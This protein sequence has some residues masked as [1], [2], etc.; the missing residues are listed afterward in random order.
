MKVVLNTQN[1]DLINAFIRQAKNIKS[2]IV[3]AK[4]EGVLFD[5]IEQGTSNYYLLEVNNSYTSKAI[6]LI[7]KINPYSI[8]GIICTGSEE[9]NITL[10]NKADIYFFF[11]ESINSDTFSYTTLYSLSNL[12][13]NLSILHK[14]TQKAEEPIKFGNITYD[15]TRRTLYMKNKEIKKL[16]AK[17][18]G[19]IEILAQN[20]GKLVRKEVILEKVWH[21]TDYF[22]GRSMD[23][24]VTHLRKMFKELG[25][26]YKIKNVSGKGLILEQ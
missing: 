10:T 3:N 9:P 15:P 16:S 18:G 6:S 23:V 24:Y 21:K 20:P 4:V 13:K 22:V 12:D 19:I 8:I 17:Q 26:S 5:T 1:V 25:I 2:E 7:K 14:L 11:N